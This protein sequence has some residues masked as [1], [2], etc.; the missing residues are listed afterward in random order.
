MAIPLPTD[1]VIDYLSITHRNIYRLPITP[2]QRVWSKQATLYHLWWTLCYLQ[3]LM[4]RPWLRP[5]VESCTMPDNH[6]VHSSF[7]MYIRTNSM[8]YQLA[9]SSISSAFWKNWSGLCTLIAGH[10]NSTKGKGLLQPL[11]FRSGHDCNA[12][13]ATCFK[14]LCC[15]LC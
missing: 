8:T 12:N 13:D 15:V 6:G 7:S 4:L 5:D 9:F 3:S 11:N 14:K 2:D 10:G 1:A